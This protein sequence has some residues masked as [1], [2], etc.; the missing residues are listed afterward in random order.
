MLNIT[1]LGMLL[2]ILSASCNSSEANYSVRAE[3]AP[4]VTT[5]AEPAAAFEPEQQ[6]SE[7]IQVRNEY[8]RKLLVQKHA[9]EIE[10]I[11]GLHEKELKSLEETYKANLRGKELEHQK[12]IEQLKISLS[13]EATALKE[14]I[15]MYQ[16]GV[17]WA[18]PLT[19]VI[20]A[21]LC[22]VIMRRL[23]EK[24]QRRMAEQMAKQMA[25]QYANYI[26]E[27]QTHTLP[28]ITAVRGK[29][30]SDYS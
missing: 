5:K 20:T 23:R 24:D 25:E 4:M 7:I 3:P 9:A 12:E 1:M 26:F 11:N 17:G 6:D 2:L 21:V 14:T 29:N 19:M 13:S 10:R 22:F 15:V 27:K 16:I 28:S 8:E 30:H 18:I